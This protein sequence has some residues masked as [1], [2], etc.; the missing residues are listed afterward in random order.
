[1][2]RRLYNPVAPLL[3]AFAVVQSVAAQTPAPSVSAGFG[4]DTTIADVHNVFSLVRA[5]LAK[6]DSTARARGIWST[7][8]Q[9]DRTVGDVTAWLVNEGFP[10]TVIG[11]VP[12]IPGD[13]IYVVRILYAN[14]DSAGHVA[15]LAMLRLYAIR[16]A[17]APYAFRLSGAFPRM[18]SDWE[19]RSKGP[20]T[21]WYVPGQRPNPGRITAAVRFVDSV[22]T[23]FTVP[24]P[25]HLDVIVAQSMDDAYRGIG[26]DFYPESSGP[27]QRTGGLNLGSI[28]L[29]GNPAIGEAYFHELVHS[30]L[31]PSLPV[32]SKLLGEGVAT[33]L[34]GSRGR[35]AREM[36]A[37]LRDYQRADSS[38]ALSRLIRTNFKDADADRSTNLLYATGALIADS[39]YR[40]GGISALRNI[41]QSKGDADALIGAISAALGFSPRDDRSLDSWW[42]TE[43]QRAT[44]AI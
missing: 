40:K 15:P 25:R 19:Q 33:W 37:L 14:A 6:P 28:I 21:F 36:Y 43:A 3:F 5:Y 16:E 13:S 35:T 12:A 38:L 17:G 26:V 23:L 22:A 32:G 31:G 8:T 39:I 11:V 18:R 42:R 34:G 10:A 1:V 4:V 2:I 29:S 44:G 9:F 27:G 7:A 30:V 24:V 41:Y 20:L